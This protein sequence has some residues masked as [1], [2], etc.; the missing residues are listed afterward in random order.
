MTDVVLRALADALPGRIPAASAGTMSNFTYGGVDAEGRPFAY[1]ETIPGG[2]GGGPAHH[3]ASG[4]Q[5][6]MTNTANTPV[7]AIEAVHPV[8]IRR[9]S[10]RAGS[11]GEGLHRGG[12]G[13]VKDIEFLEDVDVAIIGD[14]RMVGPYGL[15]G[16][17]PGRPARN[18]IISSEGEKRELAGYVQLHV[19]AG[20]VVRI[21][22]PGGGGWGTPQR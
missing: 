5:T 2:A 8:R 21:E 18:A 11:G 4:I 22:T 13:V 16:G 6:H 7:E 14:R 19:R 20:D 3:G 17:E 15:D 1:Y 10:L 12:Q 9:F